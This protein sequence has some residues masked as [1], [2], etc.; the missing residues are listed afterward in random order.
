MGASLVKSPAY[1]KQ[2][3]LFAQLA[4][5]TYATEEAT[6]GKR[7]DCRSWNDRDVCCDLCKA[8]GTCHDGHRQEFCNCD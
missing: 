6:G 1:S 4:P 5:T 8:L 3:K 2:V 7:L